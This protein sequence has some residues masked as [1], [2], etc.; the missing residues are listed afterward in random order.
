MK[1]RLILEAAKTDVNM[2]RHDELMSKMEAI[3]A[4]MEDCVRELD[5]L[6]PK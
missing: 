5:R 3:E 2:V 1:G 6:M 4:E